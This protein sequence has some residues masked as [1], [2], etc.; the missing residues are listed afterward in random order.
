[1]AKYMVLYSST[2]KASEVMASATPEQM[3]ASMDEWMAWREAA[4]KVAE[5]E[6]GMPMQAISRIDQDG[7]TDSSS[8]VSG[9]ALAVCDSK[10]AL[11]EVLKSHP[12]LKRTESSIDVFEM[13]SMPGL[14][15]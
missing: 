3:K 15:A 2:M 13:L 12:H 8:Q 10:D 14:D 1:M 9:Y 11:L 7:V 4:S 6:F 5:V